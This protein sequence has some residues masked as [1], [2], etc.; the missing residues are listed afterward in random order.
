MS[1]RAHRIEK[2][3]CMQRQAGA[4]QPLYPMVAPDYAETQKELA[5][6]IG[7]GRKPVEHGNAVAD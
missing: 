6:R 2:I 5:L 3:E 4:R 1:A 7:L